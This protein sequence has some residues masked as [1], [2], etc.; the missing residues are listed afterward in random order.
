L[1]SK[2]S[3]GEM[4]YRWP[5]PHPDPVLDEALAIALEYL[6]ATCQA[7]ADDDT[8][9]VVAG[10]VLAAWLQGARHRIRLANVGILADQQAEASR[11]MSGNLCLDVLRDLTLP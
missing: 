9:R 6:G 5:L 7:K 4:K 10:S 11:K 1:G 3:G 8:K 2:L